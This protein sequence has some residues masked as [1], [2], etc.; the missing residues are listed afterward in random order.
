MV[1]TIASTSQPASRRGPLEYIGYGLGVAAFISASRILVAGAYY[2][3][4]ELMWHGRLFPSILGVV[5]FIAAAAYPR[6]APMLMALY[7]LLGMLTDRVDILYLAAG[8]AAGALTWILGPASRLPGSILLGASVDLAARIAASGAEPWDHPLVS[9]IYGALL[10]AGGLQLYGAR[11]ESPSLGVF[12]YASLIELGILYPNALLRYA[13]VYVYSVSIIS[14]ASIMII[15]G[16]YIGYRASR[17]S[18][19]YPIIGWILLEARIPGIWGLPYS[20]SLP[21]LLAP[22]RSSRTRILAGSL[23]FIALMVAGV[24]VYA[25]PYLGLWP[26]ADRIEAVLL[27]SGLLASIYLY[28][29]PPVYNG[30]GYKT[31]AIP[32]LAILAATAYAVHVQQA[33]PPAGDEITIISYNIHQGYTYNGRLN[34]W[35]IASFLADN[36]VDIAC[37]QEVD[38]GRLTSAYIDVPLLLESRGYK[39]AYQPAIEGTYGVAIAS[40]GGFTLVEGGL[41]TS[42]GEQRA[43]VKASTH[44]YTLTNA[45]LGLDPRER[46]TQARELLNTSLASPP[47]TI[48]CGDFNEEEGDAIEE[49]GTH[50]N[51][52]RPGG[53]TCCLGEDTKLVIDYIAPHKVLGPR[54]EEYHVVEI[55]LSDHLPVMARAQK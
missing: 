28:V 51:I 38:G 8:P 16:I 50:Y 55:A 36:R 29:N 48:I 30:T 34:A 45:H 26:L 42:T 9:I 20:A 11:L 31:L 27:L 33:S 46:L 44:G 10:L 15:A 6:G 19:F 47:S 12:L 43:Y 13:G 21:G 22:G 2:S 24:G 3:L 14:L 18:W 40:T 32:V 53:P 7:G 39:V 41:L 35:D 37:L 5:L 49:L 54:L 1:I 23:L 25:Y 4:W 52:T 17:Y